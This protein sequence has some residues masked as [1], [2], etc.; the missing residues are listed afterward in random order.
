[1]SLRS[2]DLFPLTTLLEGDGEDPTPVAFDRRGVRSRAELRRDVAALA[3]AVERMGAGRWLLRVE[4][5]YAAAVSL[6]S[7][8]RSRAVAVLP[9]NG[10]P[11]T[12]RRAAEGCVGAL[13]DAAY[14][15]DAEAAG[16]GHLGIDP[17]EPPDP[18]PP[19]S[20][21]RLDRETPLAE[22][23]TSGTT[24]AGCAVSKALRHLEDEVLALEDRLGARI[25]EGTRIFATA[26]HQHI[27]GLLFRVLWPLATRR[28]FQ[29]ETLLHAGELIPRMAECDSAALVTTPVHLK[30]MAATDELRPLRGICRAVFSSGGPLDAETAKSVAQQLGD[31]PIEV[32]G[33]TETGGVAVR[34]RHADGESWVPLPGVEIRRRD[35]DGCLEVTSPYVS[36]G[37][38]RSD[39]RARALMGD[40]V[41]IAADGRFLLQGRADRVVKVAEKRLALPEMERMLELHPYV[42]EAAL[43]VREQ[44]G[45]GRIHAVVSLTGGG[46]EAL[47]RDGRRG[48]GAELTR[49][50]SGSFDPVV[51]PRAWRSVERL[52]RDAQ[53]KVT[54]AALDALFAESAGAP[55]TESQPI[56]D[57]LRILNETREGDA[58]ERRIEVTQRLPQLEGHFEGFPV[59]A[60]VVQLGWAVDAATAWLGQRP[61][62][63]GLEALK[64]PHPLLPGR[65]LTL[66]IERARE[67]HVLRFRLHEGDDVFASGRLRLEEDAA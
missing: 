5:S 13:W 37:D 18:G 33:S 10:Q 27:Y 15:T 9:P 14:R 50:L 12:L 45:E 66:R 1:M 35:D 6:L 46:R 44:A 4:N 65:T 29:S 32:F 59:V 61:R 34:R 43:L 25:P 57:G 19:V 62:L 42:A 48:F 26:S 53:D 3:S 28:A 40:R 39:G 11:Q 20:P 60:G 24:G 16:I 55:E 22:F 67:G 8:A 23:Q 21:A 47:R 54:I 51:L 17:L 7:L 2:S 64:F 49:H 31:T 38:A 41:E 56:A 58:F 52:P 36:V 30:R 63:A